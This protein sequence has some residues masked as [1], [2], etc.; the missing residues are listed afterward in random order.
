MMTNDAVRS[1]DIMASP[2]AFPLVPVCFRCCFFVVRGSVLGC[3]F[4]FFGFMKR[5]SCVIDVLGEMFRAV[6][7]GDAHVFLLIFFKI[8]FLR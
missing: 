2:H 5:W 1:V 4:I 3:V 7:L 8:Q 6:L